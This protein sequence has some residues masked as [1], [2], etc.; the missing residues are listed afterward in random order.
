MVAISDRKLS[1]KKALLISS[2]PSMLE[3]MVRPLKQAG[4]AVNACESFADGQ[5]LYEDQALIVLP[6]RDDDR[7][8]MREF[9]NWLRDGV[10]EAPY[11]LA[12][13]RVDEA[14]RQSL[15]AKFRLNDLVMMPYS[16][17]DVAERL[18]SYRKWS[19]LPES[20]SESGIAPAPVAGGAAPMT[21]EEDL[22]K[23]A[24]V[25]L[26]AGA[27][28]DQDE[29]PPE[30]IYCREAPVG[31]AM[32]DRELR[33]LLANPRWK[34]Q[35][36]LEDKELIGRRQFEVFPKLHPDWNKIYLRCLNGESRRGREVIPSH[37]GPMKMRWEVRP[38]RYRS[39]SIG[40]ITI[41]FEEDLTSTESKE[42]QTEPLRASLPADFDA[43]A[44]LLDMEGKIL[45]ANKAAEEMAAVS[46]AKGSIDL[47]DAF[48]TDGR[49]FADQLA[50]LRWGKRKVLTLTSFESFTHPK[51]NVQGRLAWSNTR[52]PNNQ[53]LRVGVFVSE[54]E[55]PSLGAASQKAAV[56]AETLDEIDLNRNKAL[57]WKANP[58]GE[59]TFFNRAW[60]DF[61]G[62]TQERELHGGWLDGLHAE[63]AS[64]TKAAVAEAMQNQEVLEH[65]LRLKSGTGDFLQVR[66][67]VKPV[68][69]ASRQLLGFLGIASL[70]ED[71]GFASIGA[72]ARPATDKLKLE[73]QSLETRAK[74]AES[75]LVEA[76]QQ[77]EEAKKARPNK[78][79]SGTRAFSEMPLPLWTCDVKGELTFVSRQWKQFRGRDLV[80]ETE[81]QW[82]EGI[83]NEKERDLVRQQLVAALKE[84]VPF[85]SRFEWRDKDGEDRLVEMQG[86]PLLDSEGLCEGMAGTVRDIT[87]EHAALSTVRQ[88]VMPDQAESEGATAD[89]FRQL[90]EKLPEWK[91]GQKKLQA[92]MSTFREIFGKVATGIVLLSPKG[93]P[94]MANEQHRDLLGFSVEEAQDMEGWLRRGCPDPEH[95]TAV[96]KVWEEDI[97]RRQLVRVLA[98][99]NA[100]GVLREIEIQPQLFFDDNRLLLTMRDV[101]DSRHSEEALRDSE[102]RF[103]SLFRDSAVGIALIDAEDKIYDVNPSLERILAIPRRQLLAH[104]LDDHIHEEDLPRKR[105]LLEQL[106]ASPKRSAFLELRLTNEKLIDGEEGDEAWVRLH[107]AIV[108]DA[109]QQVLFTAYFVHDIVEQ[110]AVQAELEVSQEQNRALL[111]AIPN[112]VML[113]DREGAIIDFLPSE[114]V[115]IYVPDDEDT[116]GRPMEELIPSFSGH[117]SRLIEEAYR[118]DDVIHFRYDV[119][120]GQ[121]ANRYEARIVACKPD[122]A[123]ISI[124]KEHSSPGIPQGLQQ[125][126]LCFQHGEDAI[127][128]ADS[129]GEVVDWNGSAEKLFGFAR[130]GAAG[131]PL[132]RLFACE[133]IDEVCERLTKDEVR[134][135][136]R[137]SLDFKGKDG[138]A[139]VVEVAYRVLRSSEGQ[140]LGQMLSMRAPA[141]EKLVRDKMSAEVREECL[142]RMVPQ[143]HQRLRNNLQIIGTLLNLQYKAQPDVQTQEVLLAG[144]NRAFALSLLHEQIDNHHDEVAVD[145]ANFVNRL[146]DHL[147]KCYQAADRVVV[148][149]DILDQLDLQVASP[150]ALIINEL[151]SNAIVHGF[152]GDDSGAVRVRLTLKD[153]K[154]ELSVKDNGQ[155]V[156]EV[157][158]TSRNPELGLQIAET[159]AKQI[160]GNLEKIDTTE[161][162][163]R[164]YFT[165]TLRK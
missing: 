151:L 21:G 75:A 92:D 140:S 111:E 51:T 156:S 55:L 79:V 121:E 29:E 27:R 14:E 76:R 165:T 158:K 155:G 153:G 116:L 152:P 132:A 83:A 115:P 145:F 12:V 2:G 104:K 146:V 25:S 58:L 108:R 65:G 82:M 119:P 112:L 117:L 41:A 6:L 54:A 32:L 148:E 10:H 103:R 149:V 77:L 160:G 100:S 113:V 125:K 16:E 9:V 80:S 114:D 37:D 73:L 135:V 62:R 17:D 19:R 131:Q 127:A 43:P 159:L 28:D 69:N 87:G 78:A 81:G 91:N 59:I 66:L 139:G 144:R 154:G 46:L 3:K 33:Y 120:D 45:K 49:E 64:A 99:A 22:G 1:F 34:K 123:V 57:V 163:F 129:K 150:L 4:M 102:L 39:G 52:R 164:V 23:T 13:G 56:G 109:D 137:G 93:E 161:T 141:D 107:I 68:H 86:N 128:I 44:V 70:S 85:K 15:V 31:I 133:S 124:K 74:E 60:L 98:L 142:N 7:A 130:Q 118:L 20:Q 157:P 30:A 136:W 67:E 95:A 162:E 38:W 5:E 40:G 26:F 138:S 110:K 126:E 18:S 90:Q 147:L 97:W 134:Q 35:F 88:L 48:P 50:E 96:L 72:A 71:N 143:M 105:A 106:L 8:E 94:E 36:H 89:L 122:N 101:T 47:L 42:A 11:I 63:D 84:G 53:I 24:R 61:R